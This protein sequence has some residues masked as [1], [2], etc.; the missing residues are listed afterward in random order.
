MP[1]A[2]HNELAMNSSYLPSLLFTLRENVTNQSTLRAQNSGG[3]LCAL[4]KTPAV[5]D[6]GDRST[7]VIPAE[8]G[9][10]CMTKTARFPPPRE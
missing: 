8:A 2:A 9:I 10:Q 3:E 7:A 4:D 5:N 1:D 6:P